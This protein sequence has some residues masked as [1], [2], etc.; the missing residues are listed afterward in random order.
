MFDVPRKKSSLKKPNI[1]PTNLKGVETYYRNLGYKS[2]P[3]LETKSDADLTFVKPLPDGRRIHVRVKK[4]TK[5]FTHSSHIDKTDPGR[6]MIGH[7]LNDVLLDKPK[8]QEFRTPIRKKRS[9]R[10]KKSR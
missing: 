1:P 8:H 6:S 10:S 2:D 7:L 5:Y 4:G 3:V 9:K